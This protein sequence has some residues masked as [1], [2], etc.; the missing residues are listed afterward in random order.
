MRQDRLHHHRN[1]YKRQKRAELP[2]FSRGFTLIELLVVMAILSILAVIVT[3]TFTSSMR[4]GRDSRRKDDLRS[5]S[6][7]LETY[8]NDKGAYPTGVNGVM[9][10]CDALDA[11][12]CNW[13][14]QFKDNK[15]TLYMVL[16]PKD[17]L[18]TQKYY[19]VSGGASYKLY[20]KLENTL[21]Q[22]DGVS[23]AGYS[24]TSCNFGSTILC[25]YGIAST[26]TTP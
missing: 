4:R 19:Y 2:R 25:T 14:G 10:G 3:G 20:A 13:G 21:D 16:I 7:A 8:F 11:Q 24:G 1:L 6:S 26:N 18:E 9:T 22:G 15:G 23:Q 5:I 17:P 12:P